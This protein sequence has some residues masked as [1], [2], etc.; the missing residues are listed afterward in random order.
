MPTVESIVSRGFFPRE[1]PPA[2]ST[3]VLGQF[4]AASDSSLPHEFI[5]S[6]RKAKLSTHNLARSGTLR[7][8]LGIPN[9]IHFYRLASFIANNWEPLYFFTANSH[10]SLTKPVDCKT[11]RAIDRQFEL[12]ERVLQR[13]RIRSTARYIVQ[14]DISRFYPSIYTHSIPWALHTKSVAKSNRSDSLIGNVLDKLVRNA[15]DGQTMG[16]PIGPDSS[17]LIAEI[18]LS[19]VDHKLDIKGLINGFR[20]IDDYEFGF[21]TLAEAEDA[22]SQLQ[23]IL[24]EYELALNP[25]KTEIINLPLP[26]EHPAISEIRVFN[27]RSTTVGQQSDLIRYFDRVFALARENPEG[28]IIAYA[29][30]RLSGVIVILPANMSL[31]ENLLLQSII[32]EPGA[33][34]QVLNQLLRLREAGLGFDIERVS[35]VL[36]GVIQQHAPKGHGSEV[37]W[38][39]WGLIVFEMPFEA[40]NLD[41]AIN[42]NDPVVSILL[43][44]AMNKSLL[45]KTADISHFEPIMT[46]D[47]L[48][49][50]QWLLSYEANVKGWVPSPGG[51]DHVSAEP[52]F[53]F[54]KSHN[55]HFYDD[56][57]STRIG[58]VPPQG[59]ISPY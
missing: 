57:L 1:L 46:T 33:I 28:C 6:D 58:Y 7:R 32:N 19:A 24:C 52:C 23:N 59:W 20:Y 30:S 8:Q 2:F 47:E 36:N 4:L 42:M 31:L 40:A 18:I 39:I 45:P 51:N 26:A 34:R 5:S 35:Q 9:P 29:V 37:A 43:L 16:I 55:I 54:L 11:G 10:L 53:S 25:K 13:S 49:G 38:A 44:D 3:F 27:F 56:T 41:V 50:D 17:L 14:T 21:M 15:Q 12:H 48:Y 22:I